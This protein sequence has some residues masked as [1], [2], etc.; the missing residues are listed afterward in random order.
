MV[1]N[2]FLSVSLLTL[3]L[4]IGCEKTLQD[5]SGG[6]KKL[7]NGKDLTGWRADGGAIWRVQDGLLVGTQGEN[8]APGDLF[9][10][11]VYQDFALKVDYRVVWPCNSGVWFRYQSPEVAYQ[12]D[13]LEYQNPECYSG[14]LYCPSK[15]FLAMNTDKALVSRDG[16]NT[17]LVQAQGD[18][19]QI[20][21]NGRQVADVHD[22]TTAS[23][24][25]GFQVHPGQEFGPMKI[26]VRDIQIKPL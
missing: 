20:W 16:W 5:Q 7:F 12:A 23:G 21:L 13:I 17:L 2:L 22:T 11:N 15:M 18:H 8:N 6:Y 4:L 19:L 3:V 24:T 9:T 14:T 10:E 26:M 25:I 1:K